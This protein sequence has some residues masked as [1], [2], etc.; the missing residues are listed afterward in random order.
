VHF[1]VRMFMILWQMREDA[2]KQEVVHLRVELQQQNSQL[3][4][5]QQIIVAL[6][7]CH[8]TVVLLLLI[9]VPYQH[10]YLSEDVSESSCCLK[11]LA[12]V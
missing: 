1:T 10:G 3:Q 11:I 4:S 9:D 6:Q 2:L 8:A 12:W 5:N 7:V